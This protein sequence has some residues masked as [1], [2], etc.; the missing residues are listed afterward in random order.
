MRKILTAALAFGFVLGLA[1][2]NTIAGIGKDVEK[3]G[4]VVQDAARK[5]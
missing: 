2:C 3:A 5:R 4:E 1:G